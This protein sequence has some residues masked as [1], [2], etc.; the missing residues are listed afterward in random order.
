MLGGN[1]R[2]WE[3][4]KNTNLVCGGKD[5]QDVREKL[6]TEYGSAWLWGRGAE[7]SSCLQLRS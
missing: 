4:S 3:N 2:K 7:G 6:V 1:S 5:W